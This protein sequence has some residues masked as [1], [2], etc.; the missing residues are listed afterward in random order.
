MPVIQ[1]IT[2]FVSDLGNKE[3]KKKKLGAVELSDEKWVRVGLFCNLLCEYV[4]LNM[5]LMSFHLSPYADEAQ[6]AFLADID[7]CPTP[8]A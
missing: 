4:L 2:S 7:K 8:Y 3:R 5:L 6:Q 1:S